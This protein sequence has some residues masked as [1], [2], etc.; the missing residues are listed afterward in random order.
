MPLRQMSI[1]SK[2]SRIPCSAI[3]SNMLAGSTFDFMQTWAMSVVRLTT[4]QNL[5]HPRILLHMLPHLRTCLR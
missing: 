2:P 3:I 4:S 5:D 1:P